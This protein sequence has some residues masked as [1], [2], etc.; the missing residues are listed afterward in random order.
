MFCKLLR[1]SFLRFRFRSCFRSRLRFSLM[2]DRLPVLGQPLPI[3]RDQIEGILSPLLRRHLRDL[4]RHRRGRIAPLGVFDNY[5]SHLVKVAGDRT[6]QST[7]RGAE[8]CCLPALRRTS[9]IVLS[10]LIRRP[11]YQGGRCTQPGDQRQDVGEHLTRHRPSAI[12][13]VT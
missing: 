12:W 10:R 7:A 9:R 4:V 8:P 3:A 13:N 2:L 1:R 5:K 11:L 6:G